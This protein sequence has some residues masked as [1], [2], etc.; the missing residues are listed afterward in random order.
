MNCVEA[1]CNRFATDLQSVYKRELVEKDLRT[2]M[3]PQDSIPGGNCRS[4]AGLLP[5][6]IPE[7]LSHPMS[8]E[9]LFSPKC[10]PVQDFTANFERF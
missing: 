8:Y 5:V 6:S 1:A 3:D 2:A 7:K 10:A 9:G 4:G